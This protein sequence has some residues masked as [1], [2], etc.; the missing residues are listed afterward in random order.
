[1]AK[2]I[3]VFEDAIEEDGRETVNMTIKAEDQVMT[4]TKDGKVEPLITHAIL[5]GTCVERC[6]TQQVIATLTGLVSEA[7][8]H[9]MLDQHKVAE[10]YKM[11]QDNGAVVKEALDIDAEANKIEEVEHI[12]ESKSGLKLVDSSD[13]NDYGNGP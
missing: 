6:F 8:V 7:A 13:N 1:M 3:I 5:V 9:K 2:V 12:K 10:E 11:S 4:P